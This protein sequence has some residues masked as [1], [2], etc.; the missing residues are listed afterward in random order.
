[1]LFFLHWLV[2]RL[3]KD[4]NFEAVVFYIADH[5]KHTEVPHALEALLYATNFISVIVEEDI[6][7]LKFEDERSNFGKDLEWVFERQLCTFYLDNSVNVLS[8][9][10]GSVKVC[11]SVSLLALMRNAQKLNAHK[12][13][14]H[15]QRK[16]FSHPF[17]VDEKRQR[18]KVAVVNHPTKS[19]NRNCTN[20][21]HYHTVHHIGAVP[22]DSRVERSIEFDGKCSTV[23]G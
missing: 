7:T 4:L 2:N 14:R 6:H 19:C 13:M 3:A 11:Y 1:M 9:D 18:R 12:C 23:F 8:M 20:T 15:P 5:I 10:P 22:C 21:T 17:L 16:N